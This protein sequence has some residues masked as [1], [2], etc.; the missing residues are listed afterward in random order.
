MDE[1]RL[2]LAHIPRDQS[3]FPNHF[4]ELSIY[5]QADFIQAEAININCL[6]IE[7]YF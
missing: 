6:G 2:R 5:R 7:K 3:Y 4:T 1:L